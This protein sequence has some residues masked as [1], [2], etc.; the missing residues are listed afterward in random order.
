MQPLITS[1][2]GYHPN[3]ED[4]LRDTIHPLAIRSGPWPF[5]NPLSTPRTR[6]GTLHT[7]RGSLTNRSGRVDPTAQTVH[8]VVS[9]AVP[10]FVRLP[11]RRSPADAPVKVCLAPKDRLLGLLVSMPLSGRE[12]VLLHGN[13]CMPAYVSPCVHKHVPLCGQ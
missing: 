8:A 9:S 12:L 4:N 11:P 2:L 7:L 1:V 10:H 3:D 13:A 6:Q 5:G